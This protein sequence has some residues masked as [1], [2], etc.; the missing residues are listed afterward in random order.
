MSRFVGGLMGPV[1]RFIVER[2]YGPDNIAAFFR[3]SGAQIG[4]R[5]FIVPTTLGTEPYLIR[6]GNHVAIADG[7]SFMTHDGAVWLFRDAVPDL[8]V[9]G[10]IVIEDNCFIGQRAILGPN[11]RIGP[12]SIVAAGSFVISDVPP[13]TLVMG[14]PARPFGSLE[15]YRAKCLERWAKQRPVDT[16][17]E[18]GETWWQSRHYQENRGRL[19][20][21]LRELFHEALTRDGVHPSE[22]L[23]VSET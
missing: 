20:C 9:F 16:T 18:Q 13:D 12:N 21:H 7:V 15:K 4:E 11:I 17:L 1:R 19:E 3:K 5:C 2:T 23:L 6:I 8:Q 10:P 22:Q 14:C